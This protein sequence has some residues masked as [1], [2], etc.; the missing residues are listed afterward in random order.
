M[1]GLRISA[2]SNAQT[3]Y[4][5][6]KEFRMKKLAV[7]LSIALMGLSLGASAKEWKT[8]RFGTDP[9]YAPFESKGPTGLVGFDID[10]GNE[11]CKRLN[12]KCV[13][14]E[15]DFDGIIPALKAK[16]IDAILSS[17]SQTP[18]RKQVIDFSDKIYNSPTRMI[19]KDGTNLQPTVESLKGKRVGVE[20]GTMQE[21]Y[22]KVYWAKKGIDVVSYQTQDMVYQDLQAGR[23]DAA[24]QDSVAGSYGFLK[25]PQ[26][27]GFSFAGPEVYDD[28]LFG[29]GTG[30]GLRKEDGDL[31]AEL[32][33]ALA[34]VIKDGTYKKIAAKYFDFD[35]YGE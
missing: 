9:S 26:G 4:Y 33:K 34:A 32:N 35:I 17:M 5:R 20:Q 8:I 16:K 11:L 23:L 21:N 2:W 18:Q 15:S 6:H 10:I 19:A 12:A 22:A 24:F 1:L 7:V 14:V 30:I 13:W 3:A 31:K 27:K 28:Q 29:K 25:L